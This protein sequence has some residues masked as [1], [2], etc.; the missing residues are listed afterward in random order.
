MARQPR[1]QAALCAR[2]VTQK[3]GP[4]SHAH[5]QLAPA[6]ES[7]CTSTRQRTTSATHANPPLDKQDGSQR[8]LSRSPAARTMRVVMW[9]P[10]LPGRA[11]STGAGTLAQL[12]SQLGGQLGGV[13]RVDGHVDSHLQVDVGGRCSGSGAHLENPST[14]SY[15]P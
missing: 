7:C 10:C 6:A 15:A 4:R 12:R 13:R 9:V 11:E 1:A 8:A 5:Q 2:Q 3:H 14:T